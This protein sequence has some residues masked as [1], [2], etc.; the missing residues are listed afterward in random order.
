M[1]KASLLGTTLLFVSGH[2]VAEDDIYQK[3]AAFAK[4]D[5]PAFHR[6]LRMG[7]N[8]GGVGWKGSGSP[9]SSSVRQ[10]A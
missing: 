1:G 7:D 6:H 5:W 3:I 9:R 2:A 8:P 10:C 4:L